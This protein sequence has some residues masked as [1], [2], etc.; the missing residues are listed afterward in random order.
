MILAQLPCRGKGGQCVCVAR[1]G[2]GCPPS[3]TRFSDRA[4]PRAPWWPAARNQIQIQVPPNSQIA[5]LGCHPG[6]EGGLRGELGDQEGGLQAG[7]DA[8]VIGAAAAVSLTL[9]VSANGCGSRRQAPSPEAVE[10]AAS[11]RL[12]TPRGGRAR[13]QQASPYAPS[14]CNQK[15]PAR[16]A[17]A[18][19]NLP[20]PRGP[21]ISYLSPGV[22]D[23]GSA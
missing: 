19:E 1:P 4:R 10:R 21:R 12:L 5:L 2:S 11:K 16:H 7:L 17:D 14:R 15:A 8:L 13:H 22:G 23:N 6:L 18:P 9:G 20:M 3:T